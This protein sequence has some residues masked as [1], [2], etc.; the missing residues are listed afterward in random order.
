MLATFPSSASLV[1]HYWALTLGREKAIRLRQ[2]IKLLC[3]DSL[4]DIP[5]FVK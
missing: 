4:Q 3:Y 1:R 2:S 5:E